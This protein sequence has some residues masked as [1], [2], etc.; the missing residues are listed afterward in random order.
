MKRFENFLAA[1]LAGNSS[2]MVHKLM[3]PSSYGDG[4]LHPVPLPEEGIGVVDDFQKKFL[5]IFAKF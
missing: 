2:D 4:N 3:S 5:A 1:A